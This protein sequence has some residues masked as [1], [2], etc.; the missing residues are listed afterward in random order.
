MFVAFSSLNQYRETD[1]HYPLPDSPS[2]TIVPSIVLFRWLRIPCVQYS[3]S[4]WRP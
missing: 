3:L 2:V 1:I 4:P